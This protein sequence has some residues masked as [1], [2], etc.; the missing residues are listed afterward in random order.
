[1]QTV[2]QSAVLKHLMGAEDKKEKGSPVTVS[3]IIMKALGVLAAEAFITVLV[4]VGVPSAIAA[5]VASI[6]LLLILVINVVLGEP[7]DP[8][9]TEAEGGDPVDWATG[10]AK[11][12]RVRLPQSIKRSAAT[13]YARAF[14]ASFD[15]STLGFSEPDVAN[16][17]V[18]AAI[19][20]ESNG[21]GTLVNKWDYMGLMQLNPESMR[22]ASA[23]MKVDP[24]R[25]MAQPSSYAHA[26]EMY[27]A[28]FKAAWTKELARPTNVILKHLLPRVPTSQ[29]KELL[30]AHFVYLEGRTNKLHAVIRGGPEALRRTLSSV[31][32]LHPDAL[33]LT[34]KAVRQPLLLGAVL[35]AIPS[36]ATPVESYSGREEE[37]AQSDD[38]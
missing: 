21:D 28:E 30:A 9:P 29:A 4:A 24:H 12:A 18:R 10:Y 35:R 1:M 26:M 15:Q 36:S 6:A 8:E 22:A 16:A 23:A 37:D 2:N 17:F 34:S 25:I 11:D 32:L 19:A 7:S 14:L 38:E 27:A 31:L 33:T 13:P 3:G 20:Y 5:L